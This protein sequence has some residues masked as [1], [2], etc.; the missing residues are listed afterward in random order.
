MNSNKKYD[1]VSMGEMIVDFTRYGT[2]ENGYTLY[3]QNPGGGAANIAASVARLGGSVA[4]L[5]KVGSDCIGNALKEAL[6]HENVDIS[7]LVSDGITKTSLAFVQVDP[8][9]ERSFSFYGETPAHLALQPE[10][11]NFALLRSTEIL[12][13][14]DKIL[15]FPGIQQTTMQAVKTAKTSGAK[16]AFDPNIRLSL[17]SSPEVARATI[18]E[19]LPNC[20]YIK[21]SVE[22]LS[23]LTGQPNIE[24][25]AATIFHPGLSLLVITDGENG[26]YAFTT[27]ETVSHPAYPAKAIDTT[28]AG[29][30]FWGG[31]LYQLARNRGNDFP[32]DYLID[33]LSFSCA[34]G[35]LA[36]TRKGAV[37]A[38]PTLEMVRQLQSQRR[39]SR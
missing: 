17:W 29:D 24:K 14:G 37:P 10:E 5:G 23:F 3:E 20:N 6:L 27:S 34:C 7:G 28:G 31:T 19:H 12:A 4:F 32:P 1:V 36:V 15:A 33:L 2:S 35:A 9:G 8:R 30:A 22:E 18:L 11:L 39:T 13:Y 26:A 16:I 25:A 38:M 21:L